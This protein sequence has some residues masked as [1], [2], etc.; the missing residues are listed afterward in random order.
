MWL[1]WV[2]GYKASLWSWIKP[3]YLFSFLSFVSSRSSSS[4]L[5]LS[6]SHSFSLVVCV[7]RFRPSLSFIAG[8]LPK[9]VVNKSSHFLAPRVSHLQIKADSVSVFV[10]VLILCALR[11]CRV[12]WVSRCQMLNF[13]STYSRNVLFAV[14]VCL[15]ADM[16]TFVEIGWRFSR[17][18][19]G[20]NEESLYAQNRSSTKCANPTQTIHA[21]DFNAMQWIQKWFS[22]WDLKGVF[23][24]YHS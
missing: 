17:E 4:S 1:Q 13:S 16:C 22:F 9:W 15:L 10:D 2:E 18:Q 21:D 14:F 19:P 24:K 20:R 3:L 6:H 5:T 23:F 7:S 12:K 8:S 11:L